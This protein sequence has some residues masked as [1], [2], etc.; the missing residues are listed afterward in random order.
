MAY[1]DDAY[2]PPSAHRIELNGRET[3]TVSGVEDVERFDEGEIVL[4][5]TAGILLVTGEDAD[6]PSGGLLS[7]LFGG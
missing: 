7:R 6:R 4:T 5:T 1:R 2:A 3:L